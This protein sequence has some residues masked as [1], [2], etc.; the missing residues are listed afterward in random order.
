M[1]T[2]TKDVDAEF[3]AVYPNKA[4][5]TFSGWRD[6]KSTVRNVINF[7]IDK[8][9][10]KKMMGGDETNKEHP[11]KFTFVFNGYG[12]RIE[13]PDNF[14]NYREFGN[15]LESSSKVFT[16]EVIEN[17]EPDNQDVDENDEWSYGDDLQDPPF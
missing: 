6:V 1:S 17:K 5:I 9:R 16:G 2:H 8:V 3:G 7:G 11:L 12:Y 13:V 10:N 4:D 15:P 14:G